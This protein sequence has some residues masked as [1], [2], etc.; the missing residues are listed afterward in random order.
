M[1]Q[2]RKI[3]TVLAALI[4]TSFIN[5]H[6]QSA[7]VGKAFQNI[8]QKHEGTKGV[9]C[10]TAAKGSGLEIMK[11]MF[12]K[13]FGKDFM[14]GV[15]SITFIEYGD[16]PEATCAALRK[17]LDTFTSL[18]EEIDLSGEKQFADNKYLRCFASASG[19]NTVSDFVIAIEDDEAKML[20]YM[21]G[22]IKME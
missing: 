21:A 17:D 6:A 12:N 16:A 18:L 8:V 13:E 20:M 9:T 1:K 7:E 11:M 4:V 19:E 15:T 5:C 14:K 10:M 3:L 22:T 2:T